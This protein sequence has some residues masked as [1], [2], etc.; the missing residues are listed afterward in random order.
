M[1]GTSDSS[2]SWGRAPEPPKRP[3]PVR[4]LLVAAALLIVGLIVVRT[5]L[6]VVPTLPGSTLPSRVELAA[7]LDDY[8]A[9]MDTHDLERFSKTYDT[10]RAQFAICQEKLFEQSVRTG[11]RVVRFFGVGRIERWND[12]VRASV[13]TNGYGF[14]RQYFRRVAD[15]WILTEPL[16]SEVGQEHSKA[17]GGSTVWWWDVDSDVVDLLGSDVE[18]VRK[19]A[20][21]QGGP[22]PGDPFQVRLA[23]IQTLGPPCGYVGQAIRSSSSSSATTIVIRELGLTPGYDR[24]G[25]ETERTLQHEALHWIQDERSRGAMQVLPWWMIEGWPEARTQPQSALHV[26]SALCDK[27]ALTVTDLSSGPDLKTPGELVAREYSIAAA[28]VDAMEKQYGPDMYWKL[29]DAFRT[30]SNKGAVFARAGLS[31][32]AVWD[33]M[34]AKTSKC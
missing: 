4:R 7:A 29:F 5:V 14:V 6:A 18:S 10:T 27:P 12:Y 23:P 16:L 1:S 22:P 3:I 17:Y 31:E 24:V 32:T 19:F 15:R 8:A 21:A 28:M 2:L 13:D 9:A 30:D 25:E 34:V 26:R 33:A 11:K 20:I